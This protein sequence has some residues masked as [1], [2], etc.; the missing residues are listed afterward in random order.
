MNQVFQL[1]FPNT[2]RV[3]R[4]LI[5]TDFPEKFSS[6]YKNNE[7]CQW[8]SF[9]GECFQTHLGPGKHIVHTFL[10]TVIHCIRTAQINSMNQFYFRLL[11]PSTFRVWKT[12]FFQCVP[13]NC[14]SLYKNCTNKFD[15]LVFSAI[16]P[17]THLG[18][19]KQRF[20]NMFL[21]PVIHCIKDWQK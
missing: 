6:Y 20:S 10:G 16:V 2:F 19:G 14:D 17:N 4:T 7:F 21:R 13:K 3:W 5:F 9:F 15:E 12:L 18:S 8:A 11:F 1:L